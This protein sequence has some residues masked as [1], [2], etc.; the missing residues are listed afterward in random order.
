MPDP[1]LSLL[2]LLRGDIADVVL[3]IAMAAV[4]L[5]SAQDKLRHRAAAIAEVRAGGLPLPALLLAATIGVQ[6]AGGLA[7]ISPWP[8]AVA[9]G[10]LILAGFTLTATLLF[11]RFWL[12]RGEVRQH[13]LTAFL[14]H[15]V[16]IAGLLLLAAQQS[17]RT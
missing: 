14:E 3:R 12:A 13:Q 8:P 10:A 9:L 17:V 11:H 2:T 15:L 1:L 6:L 4:F 5:H 16:M 7:L